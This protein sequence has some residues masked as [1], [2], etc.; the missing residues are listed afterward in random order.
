MNESNARPEDPAA[1]SEENSEAAPVLS[2][3]VPEK[4]TT[5]E[6]SGDGEPVSESKQ[7]LIER[8]VSESGRPRRETF[9]ALRPLLTAEDLPAIAF[10]VQDPSPKLSSRVTSLLARHGRRD[11]FEAQLP[12]LKAGKIAILT[13][14]F[15]KISSL[16]S[17]KTSE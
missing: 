11:L 10:A 13:H 16:P 3:A 9:K 15:D 2:D 14:R 7:S 1:D 17:D 5:P 12:G 8:F 4:D 6:E